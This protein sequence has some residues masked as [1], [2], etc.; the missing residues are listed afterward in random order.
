M[1][2]T[3]GVANADS[4]GDHTV[5]IQA[6]HREVRNLQLYDRPGNNMLSKEI[7]VEDQF[8]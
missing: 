6:N 4:D 2:F 5:E 7:A 3:S 8:F 1:A